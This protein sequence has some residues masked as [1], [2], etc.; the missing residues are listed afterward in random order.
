M[1]QAYGELPPIDCLLC[2]VAAARQLSFR[3]AARE[4]ALSPQAFS[5]RIQR[6]EEIVGHALF[7][8][9]TRKVALTPAGERFRGH[10]SRIVE[11]AATCK[12]AIEQGISSPTELTLGTRYELGC[13]WL[14]PALMKRQASEPDDTIH[15]SFGDAPALHQRLGI[16][17][18]DAM[19]SSSRLEDLP[20]D[21][22]P[23]HQEEYRF[24]ASPKLLLRIPL[25][26]ARDLRNHTLLDERADQPLFRYLKDA[27]RTEAWR[28]QRT[29]SLGTIHVIR[30]WAKA[31]RG[32]AVLPEY[33]VRRDLAQGRLVHVLPRH[34]LAADTF[35]LV[36][37]RG[38]A[39]EPFLRRLAAELRGVPL[40]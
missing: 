16:G 24:V 23:L 20:F 18:I 2:F 31:G 36:W 40:R 17:A 25:K 12:G 32:V 7:A 19:V 14:A 27:I 33:L 28:A 5:A 38:S 8:R 4:V 11:L 10:A 21:Y 22:E 6:L 9:T 1:A 13:S 15:L 30:D 3:R 35:R 34:K 37:K 29:L 39:L 26:R